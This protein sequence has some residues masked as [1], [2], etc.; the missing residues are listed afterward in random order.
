[1]LH[2][3]TP[4]RTRPSTYSRLRSSSTTLSIPACPSMC[5]SSVPAGPAPMI[6][7]GTFMRVAY[8]SSGQLGPDCTQ[9]GGPSAG[10]STIRYCRTGDHRLSRALH[11]D[12]A[13]RRRRGAMPRW[14]RSDTTRRT[15]VRRARSRCPTTRSGRASE[16]SATAVPARPWHRPHPV[17][18]TGELD[19][20]PRRQ[21]THLDV[22]DAA[23]QRADPAG[24]RPLPVELR[25]G[26]PAPAVARRAD[27]RLGRRTAAVRHRDGVRRLQPEPRPVGR[28]LDR[29]AADRP[30]LVP[31]LRG[32]GAS[33]TCRR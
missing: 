29:A 27:R 3:S 19:G 23:L 17:L 1:M 18:A 13:R 2:S 26:V 31:A 8:P 9:A 21:R 5:D 11:D 4:A 33:S 14:Q 22:L 15:W 30:L 10:L 12:A 16:V 24:V 7:T 32:D 20:P 28:V 6:T 25:A